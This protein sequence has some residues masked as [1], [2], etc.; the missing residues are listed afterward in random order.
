M[1][2]CRVKVSCREHMRARL[3]IRICMSTNL[4]VRKGITGYSKRRIFD[5]MGEGIEPIEEISA[6][7][8]YDVAESPY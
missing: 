2:L 7:T 5:I 1:G 8:D 4:E 6:L 3:V